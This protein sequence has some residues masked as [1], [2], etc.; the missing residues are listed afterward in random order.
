MQTGDENLN[1]NEKFPMKQ[2]KTILLIVFVLAASFAAYAWFFIWN[3]APVNVEKAKAIPVSA[4]A[5]FQAYST[6]EQMA[7]QSYLEK[8]LEVTGEVTT[9]T[10]NAEGFTVVLLKT[11]D[12]VFG[13]NCTL[14][15]S[16]NEIK[17]GT[18][19]TL[20]GICTGYLTDVVLIR[21]YKIK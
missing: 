4:K 13:I 2:L 1:L 5:L 3:Q 10:M 11:D 9:V 6:N 15:K 14:E 19:I 20:K 7:N 17:Q 18:R 8:I 16:T 21:C 12:P